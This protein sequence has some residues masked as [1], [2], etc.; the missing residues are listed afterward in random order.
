MSGLLTVDFDSVG[1]AI[2]ALDRSQLLY[3]RS[4]LAAICEYACYQTGRPNTQFAIDC[5]YGN[6]HDHRSD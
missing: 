5:D 4:D 1:F 2:S 3:V 6:K